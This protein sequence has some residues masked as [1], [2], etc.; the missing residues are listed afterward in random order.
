MTITA[1]TLRSDL[2]PQVKGADRST[3]R[4]LPADPFYQDVLTRA[5]NTL[6]PL[7]VYDDVRRYSNFLLLGLLLLAAFGCWRARRS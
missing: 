4:A 3:F 7:N 2:Q 5:D 1:D 6:Q